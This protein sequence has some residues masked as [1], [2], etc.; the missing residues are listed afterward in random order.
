MN[1]LALEWASILLALIPQML[2]D[3]A[4]AALTADG[5][6]GLLTWC[7]SQ[8]ITDLLLE[9]L[10]ERIAYPWNRGQVR[11]YFDAE[12]LDPSLIEWSPL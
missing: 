5:I 4:V 1:P 10:T 12:N 3:A 2:L 7:R 8:G 11:R 6:P 9:K